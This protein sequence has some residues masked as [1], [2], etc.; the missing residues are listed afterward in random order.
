[1]KSILGFQGK[2]F[3]NKTHI[4]TN[5]V[6]ICE[7]LP[8]KSIFLKYYAF[9]AKGTILLNTEADVNTAITTVTINTGF[10]G[11]LIYLFIFIKSLTLL[12]LK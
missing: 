6:I 3:K 8:G 1:M 12:T 7:Q 9:K 5:P 10:K 4:H 11:F 2:L